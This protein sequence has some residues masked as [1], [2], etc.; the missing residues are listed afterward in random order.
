MK[1]Y[2]N[3][4]IY[5]NKTVSY[6][7][8]VSSDSFK[9]TTVQVLPYEEIEKW[10]RKNSLVPLSVRISSLQCLTR[11]GKQEFIAYPLIPIHERIGK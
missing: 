7:L 8:A 9:N 2:Q 5:M 3:I 11:D 1:I 10:I 4:G 6:I